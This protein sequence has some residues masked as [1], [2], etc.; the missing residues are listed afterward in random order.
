MKINFIL[1]VCLN[2]VFL[3]SCL[4]TEFKEST[5]ASEKP[6]VED[7]QIEFATKVESTGLNVTPYKVIVNVKTP[8]V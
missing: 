7:M 5:K 8:K 6:A 2:S 4:E 1:Y 3:V